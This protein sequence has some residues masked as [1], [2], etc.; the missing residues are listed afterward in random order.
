M[1][2]DESQHNVNPMASIAIIAGGAAM[3]Q[4]PKRPRPPKPPKKEPT[5]MTDAQTLLAVKDF[6]GTTYS[7]AVKEK[8]KEITH[9]PV[10]GPGDISTR[11]LNPS[12]ITLRTNAQ[13]VIEGCSFG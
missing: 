5:P 10:I 12:R 8:F 9:R 13:G 11:E 1:P 7:P 4:P 3:V 6:I 2:K